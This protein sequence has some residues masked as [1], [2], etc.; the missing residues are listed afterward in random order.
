MAVEVSKVPSTPGVYK[1]FSNHEIIYIGKAKNLKKRVSSYFGKSIKDRKTSQIKFLTDNIETFTTKNEVEA[2]LLEQMLI[3]E[4][5]PKFNILLRDD[6]TYPYIYF[7]LD[8]DFPGIYSKR[9]KQ[10]V[11][12]NFFGPFVS[13]GAVKKSIK[14]IQRIF[15][16]RNCNDSTFS[17]RS[18]PCIEFQMKRCSAP[19]VHKISKV[20][21]FED[22]AS[23]KSY[24]SSSDSQTINR[25]NSEIEKASHNLE[26]EKAAD[27]RD[28]LKRL[29]LLR[30]EQ[31]VVTLARDVDIFSVYAEDDYL[32]ICIIV[33]RRGKIRGTKTHLIKRA[34]YESIDDVYQSAILNFYDNQIDIPNKIL[35]TSS[36][37]T[38]ELIKKVIKKKFH[39]KVNITHSPSRAIRSIYNLCKI[40]AKQVIQNHLSKEDRYNFAYKEL[41]SAM[42]FKIPIKRI[43]AYD[44]SHISGDHAVASCIIFS[45]SG[46]SNQDYRLF[47]IPKELSGNDVGSLKHVMERRLKYYKDKETKPDIIL[48][49][50]GRAQLKFAASVIKASKHKDIKVIS[51]VKG[52]DR[53]RATET[54]LS[55]EGIIEFDKYSK[56]FLLLQEARD[57]SHRFAVMAQRKKKRGGIKKSKLDNIDGIGEVLKKRLILK[58]KNIKNIKSSNIDD[59]MTVKG[60]NAKIANSIKEKL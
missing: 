15:R 34:Y 20:D 11:N 7:S 42:G 6:K 31:S 25:L 18:R 22:V 49:D 47:N 9:T 37:D 58:Y 46:P 23:A 52:S 45:D 35:C 13:S 50:G 39:T 40:N 16:L 41:Q 8:H 27:I 14:E 17:N 1:F 51:I 44:V 48:I 55:E 4:N 10:A 33:V 28:R 21:Y 38:K 54:I 56:A 5:K 30:E 36:L 43:E 26:F 53:V 29:E 57:E 12:S 2:L 24:L 59:L 60:I 32:G 19:C 3:K